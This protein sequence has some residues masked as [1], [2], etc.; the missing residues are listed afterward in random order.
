[1]SLPWLGKVKET[2]LEF[3]PEPLPSLPGRDTT[4]AAAH[5]GPNSLCSFPAP[6]PWAFLTH[7]LTQGACCLISPARSSPT[8]TKHSLL[9][10]CSLSPKG[11]HPQ[12]TVSLSCQGG[13]VDSSPSL[14]DD[15]PWISEDRDH[16]APRLSW[17]KHPPRILL[18]PSQH[19]SLVHDSAETGTGGQSQAPALLPR[20]DLRL[21]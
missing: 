10:S 1:M 19:G 20:Q 2:E 21:L 7:L 4:R 14:L 5:S 15:C 12:A 8:I 6:W 17:A 9:Q 3:P 11:P 18:V 16:A 13:Q